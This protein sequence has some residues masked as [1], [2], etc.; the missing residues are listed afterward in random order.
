MPTCNP[1]IKILIF[2]GFIHCALTVNEGVQQE[3]ASA[4]SAEPQ[5]VKDFGTLL[6]GFRTL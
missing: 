4:N 3:V 6:M 2:S 5:T 1:L